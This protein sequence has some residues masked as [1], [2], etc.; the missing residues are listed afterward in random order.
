MGE[1]LHLQK[2]EEGLIKSKG[3]ITKKPAV[4]KREK[5]E[6]NVT[7]A[8]GGTR[9]NHLLLKVIELRGPE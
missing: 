6:R 8:R 9:K 4:K 1:T 5:K 3:K 2:S 7:H